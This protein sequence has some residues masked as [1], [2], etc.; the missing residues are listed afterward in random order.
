MPN[1]SNKYDL[2]IT[3]ENNLAPRH[4]HV[5]LPETFP[6]QTIAV[7]MHWMA[8]KWVDIHMENTASVN[9]LFLTQKLI[10]GES[11]T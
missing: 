3:Q 5:R 8:L 2:T 10:H 11:E 7:F 1:F 9:I 4:Q 6:I